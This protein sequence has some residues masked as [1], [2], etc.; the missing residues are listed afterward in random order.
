[1]FTYTVR[2]DGRLM[3]KVVHQGKP[4]YLYAK[5][6]ET[7][8]NKFFDLQYK[9]MNNSVID[10]K[11]ITF[12]QY[13]EN[14]FNINCTIKEFATQISIKNRLK[15]MYEYIGNVKL[16]N[17]KPYHIQE[18]VTSMVKNG[19]TDLTKRTLMDCKRILNDAVINDIIGKNVA[20]GI[21]SPKYAK[22]ERRPLTIN[23][24]KKV[25]ELALKHKYGLFILI[26]RYCGIRCEE[27]VALTLEDIDIKN[28]KIIINK[29][30][31][32]VTNQPQI[33]STKNLKNRIIPIPNFIIPLLND[34]IK[35]NKLNNC[36]Y[37]FHKE[38]NPK[39][40]LTKQA[41]KGHLK[42]FLHEL[43]KNVKNDENKIQFSYHQLRHSYCTMLY[44]AGIKI[45]K[46]QELMGHSSAKMVYDI[47]A[48]LDEE[49][50]NANYLINTYINSTIIKK[51]VVKRV[52]KKQKK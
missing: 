46:A 1:M 17:L 8:K 26:L 28:K 51:K 6:K 24:D 33:K 49:R 38:T 34:A 36:N 45:K 14:W 32:L 23:Q 42:T 10:N 50:E 13:A 11:S 9:L 31:S 21:K 12:K 5:D 44:Y 52:V 43:N 2:K 35:Q 16:A 25:L 27:A 7:L 15:H 22:N 3:K 39:E 37:L 48:H 30:V 47:Y 41:L 18:M 29:A 4:Y 20:L 19:Y 40:M